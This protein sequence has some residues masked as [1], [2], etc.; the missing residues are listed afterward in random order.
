[1]VLLLS[2]KL[3]RSTPQRKN[4]GRPRDQPGPLCVAPVT[5]VHTS[6]HSTPPS[7]DRPGAFRSPPC[8]PF[9][10]RLWALGG[11]LEVSFE[12]PR[13]ELESLQYAAP[14]AHLCPDHEMPEGASASSLR[15]HQKSVGHTT[16]SFISRCFILFHWSVSVPLP[17]PYRLDSWSHGA[18]LRI[19]FYDLSTLHS[20]PSS[21]FVFLYKFS[22][23]LVYIEK[24]PAG[25]LI[26]AVLNL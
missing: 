8:C 23:R 26:G 18:G 6:S 24:N 2:L 20:G 7:S 25:V 21:S 12:E 5:S 9:L 14:R 3:S 13:G 11:A 4:P 16:G 17:I 10:K 1:M 15:L 19:E 22:S